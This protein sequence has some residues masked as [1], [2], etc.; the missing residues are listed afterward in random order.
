[1]RKSLL[2]VLQIHVFQIDCISGQLDEPA[3]RI[4]PK[5]RSTSTSLDQPVSIT[6]L[7]SPL[8]DEIEVPAVVMQPESLA[9]MLDAEAQKRSKVEVAEVV[10]IDEEQLEFESFIWT[11]E[12]DLRTKT[13]SPD[14]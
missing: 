11:C 9:E 3:R 12:V 8:K 6:P 14:V 5:R 1:V 13:P 4:R 7:I 2:S 10:F